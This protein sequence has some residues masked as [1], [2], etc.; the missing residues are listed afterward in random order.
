MFE[1]IHK[2]KRNQGRQIDWPEHLKSDN[3]KQLFEEVLSTLNE[4]SIVR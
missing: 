3:D 2:S 1:K 4:L